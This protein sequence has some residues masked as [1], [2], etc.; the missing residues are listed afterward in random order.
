M[1]II[2]YGRQSIDQKDIEAVTQSLQSDFLTQG[3]LVPLFEKKLCDYTNSKYALAVNSGTSALH[4]AYFALGLQNGDEFITTPLTF[5]AT[6]NAG[7]YLGA[8]PVFVDIEKA[9]GNLDPNKIEAA[10]TKKTKLIAVVDYAGHPANLKKIRQIADKYHL[11]VVEDACHALGARY[12]QT[13]IGDG[14]FAD[15]TILSFHPVKH[16]TTGE[17]GALLTNDSSVYQKAKLFR[18]HGITKDKSE[19][20]NATYPDWYYEMQLL[21]YNYRLTDLQAA[22]GISQLKKI[23]KFL[24]KRHKI[25]EFYQKNLSELDFLE[26]PIEKSDIYHA[27]HLYPV[28]MA[29]HLSQ[30]RD[31]VFRWLREQQIGVQVHYLPVYLHPYY[32]Q[33]GYKPG[34]C[35]MAEDFA[36]R[37]ISLP[38]YFDLTK[39]QQLKIIKLL[40]KLPKI[41]N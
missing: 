4:A 26:L 9:T 18:S 32:R 19:L 24:R 17:G 40:K 20:K 41:I 11:K 30:K 23:N 25:A 34:I 7:L 6:A 22:L 38:M 12:K 15:V 37:V 16:I 5:A 1:K 28:R 29:S 31:L 3:P 13:M 21:G 33:L 14:K 27:F 39:T 36:Q 2:P 10:I 8:K 35:P